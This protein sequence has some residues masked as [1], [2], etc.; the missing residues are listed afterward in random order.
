VGVSSPLGI[1]PADVLYR[2]EDVR[3]APVGDSGGG[4]ISGV[5]Y[6]GWNV[7][8]ELVPLRYGDWDETGS[9]LD[10]VEGDWTG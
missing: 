8:G 10:V 7:A 9:T 1:A 3:G 2:I 6:G 4:T 5:V